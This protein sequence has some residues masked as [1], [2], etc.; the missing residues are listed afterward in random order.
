[1]KEYINKIQKQEKLINDVKRWG[2]L[3]LVEM[4]V[5]ERISGVSKMF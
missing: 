3:L 1:M 4:G 5:D 2:S